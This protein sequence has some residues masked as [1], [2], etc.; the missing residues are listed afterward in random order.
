MT[1]CNLNSVVPTPVPTPVPITVPTPAP[2]PWKC[3]PYV[4]T[5]PKAK[6]NILQ[7][8]SKNC[9]PAPTPTLVVPPTE[10]TSI[11][12]LGNNSDCT[13]ALDTCNE[14]P[15]IICRELGFTKPTPSGTPCYGIISKNTSNFV[16]EPSLLRNCSNTSKYPVTRNKDECYSPVLT[17]LSPYKSYKL[18]APPTP[19]PTPV[20][21]IT[22]LI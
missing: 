4:P 14:L 3:P 1:C 7:W 8:K 11:V 5:T 20:N 18:S 15:P 16:I 10:Q 2:T 21:T 6:V 17:N 9:Q 19:A 12:T 13:M 22:K